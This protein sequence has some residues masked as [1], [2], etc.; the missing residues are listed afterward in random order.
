MAGYAYLVGSVIRSD[1]A[2]NQ[3]WVRVDNEGR[4]EVILGGPPVPAPIYGVAGDGVTLNPFR[5]VDFRPQLAGGPKTAF[6][7]ASVP[8]G[9]LTINKTYHIF[10][11]QVCWVNKGGAGVVAIVGNTALQNGPVYEY[12][13]TQVGVDD[14]IGVIQ[15]T[16]GGDI[17]ITR[18]ED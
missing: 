11:N 16:V 4:L 15:D 13:P 14:H 3:R 6:A 2:A 1:I 12:V 17:W 8:I 7:G 9:P 18:V 10:C 5:M